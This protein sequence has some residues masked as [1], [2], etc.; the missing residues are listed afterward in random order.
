[1]KQNHIR[2]FILS[3]I[4]IYTICLPLS[5][6]AEAEKTPDITIIAGQWVRPDGGYIVHVKNVMID[7]TVDVEYLN[8]RR[9]NVAEA[10]V[11]IWKGLV[12]LF[13]KL[14]DRGYPGSTYTLYY[15]IQND[16]L[17]GYYYQATMEKT[18]KVVFLRKNVK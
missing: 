10:T 15:N 18:Y 4:L 6:W 1:M 5:G 17:A 9:I 8:P 14:E 16:A 13:V 3:T 11:S 7:G 2:L 12:K